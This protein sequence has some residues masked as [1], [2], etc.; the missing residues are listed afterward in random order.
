ML[1]RMTAAAIVVALAA[2]ANSRTYLKNPS[3]GEVVKCGSVHP[4]TLF[5][6]G[7]VQRREA[8]CITDYK[9][10]GFVRVAGPRT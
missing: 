9:E 3:T 7:A 8:Q 2:C 5:A 6:E 10:Q 4:V 1:K